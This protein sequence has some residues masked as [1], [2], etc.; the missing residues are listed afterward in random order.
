MSGCENMGAGSSWRVNSCNLFLQPGAASFV[1]LRML[2]IHV[3]LV[4]LLATLGSGI[5]VDDTSQL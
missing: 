5:I 2:F 1:S 4:A 3:L